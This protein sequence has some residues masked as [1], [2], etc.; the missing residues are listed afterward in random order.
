MGPHRT[1][2]VRP[3]G[4]RGRVCST[5]LRKRTRVR[6]TERVNQNRYG[7]LGIIIHDALSLTVQRQDYFE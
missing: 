6:R 5:N 4:H 1:Q 7:I 3:A 2:G